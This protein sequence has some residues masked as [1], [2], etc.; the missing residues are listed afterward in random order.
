MHIV[1]T[2]LYTDTIIVML[3]VL[4]TLENIIYTSGDG[5]ECQLYL[6]VA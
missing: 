4:R 1:C 6:S 5:F 3:Y 2:S